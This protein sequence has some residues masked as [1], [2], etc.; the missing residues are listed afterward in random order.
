MVSEQVVANTSKTR[1]DA[2]SRTKVDDRQQ[3]TANKTGGKTSNPEVTKIA[4]T[5][6]N[7]TAKNTENTGNGAGHS[8]TICATKTPAPLTNG[9]AHIQK[10]KI[11]WPTKQ[12][13]VKVHRS[14]V[15]HYEPGKKRAKRNKIPTICHPTKSVDE[16]VWAHRQRRKKEKLAQ[17]WTTKNYAE[18]ITAARNRAKKKR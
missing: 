15:L 7:N 5:T 8:G 16:F 14:K 4:I 12:N 13:M 10:I 2:K 6:G 11:S 1:A 17:K 9:T 3:V 18:A